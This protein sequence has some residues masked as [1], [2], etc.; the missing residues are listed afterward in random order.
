MAMKS[1]MNCPHTRDTFEYAEAMRLLCDRRVVE[2]HLS[3][4]DKEIRLVRRISRSA[5]EQ[6]RR[7]VASHHDRE[8]PVPAVPFDKE[9]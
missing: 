2:E 3:R 4:I 6:A 8:A 1:R 9:H 7:D 5:V